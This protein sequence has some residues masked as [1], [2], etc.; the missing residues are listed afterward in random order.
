MGDMTFCRRRS[1]VLTSG[2][3]RRDCPGE[4]TERPSCQRLR[5]EMS[6][7]KAIPLDASA[8][9]DAVSPLE[10][11]P[12]EEK[13][14]RI[15]AL[16][17][18]PTDGSDDESEFEVRSQIHDH[19]IDFSQRHEMQ[20]DL[21][22]LEPKDRINL[23][24]KQ[25]RLRA[26]VAGFY[27]IKQPIPFD[28][29]LQRAGMKSAIYDSLPRQAYEFKISCSRLP[30]PLTVIE[31]DPVCIVFRR[32]NGEFDGG[33]QEVFR[34]ERLLNNR[35]PKWETLMR[36]NYFKATNE[37]V[38]ELQ[39]IKFVIADDCDPWHPQPLLTQVPTSLH[40]CE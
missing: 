31:R 14:E 13:R 39:L 20:L 4:D 10:R 8:R 12:S 15:K 28:M 25:P 35:N 32:G 36:I 11:S 22:E 3:Y 30:L 29:Y 27:G 38:K 19:Y 34:T 40:R 23:M 5:S 16:L 21:D 9:L 33:W 6:S 17:A 2:L 37:R 24:S 18:G 7:S 1:G 26:A